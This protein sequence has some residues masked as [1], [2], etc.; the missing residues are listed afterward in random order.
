MDVA[1][2]QIVVAGWKPS[3]QAP[4]PSQESVASQAPLLEVPVHEVVAG[5]KPFAGHAPDE[6]VQLSATSHC[7]AEGRHV[8][9]A[10]WKPS[11]QAPLPS[12]ESVPSQAPPLEVPVQEVV[13]AAKPFAG[14]AP[15]SP[16]QL[17]ATSHC[18]AEARHSVVAGWKP[19]T[20]APLPSQ[21]SVPSQTPPLEVPVQEVVAAAKPSAGH[22]PESPVQLSATSH[23]P[24]EARHSV[25]AG[26][27]PSTQAP[28]PSQESVPS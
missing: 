8:V 27:K 7:P 4:A 16:V 20:Q 22:A 9:V 2:R 14:H 3:T 5:A 21:E 6:P 13:A 11:T 24:A 15:E 12:Q 25:V 18:P 19:S 10:G 26:W 17:S 1:G 23:C 28:L